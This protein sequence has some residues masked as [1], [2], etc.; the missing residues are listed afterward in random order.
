MWISWKRFV[1]HFLWTLKRVQ[2]KDAFRLLH[3]GTET[4]T[5]IKQ[6]LSLSQGIHGYKVGME[7]NAT[8]LLIV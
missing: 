4:P 2:F 7:L 8:E 5:E 1:R 3:F 6:D